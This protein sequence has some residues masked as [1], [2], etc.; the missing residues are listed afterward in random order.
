MKTRRTLLTLASL[1]TVQ[2]AHADLVMSLA[3]NKTHYQISG[4]TLRFEGGELDLFLRDGIVILDAACVIDPQLFF[5]TP[6][7]IPPCPLGAT[8]FVRGERGSRL[9]D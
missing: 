2:A 7:N 3:A 9:R 4:Q 6:S 8:G 1:L 5:F